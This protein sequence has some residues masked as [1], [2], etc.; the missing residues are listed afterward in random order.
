MSIFKISIEC[1]RTLIVQ[2]LL[3]TEETYYNTLLELNERFALPLKELGILLPDEHSCLFGAL[4]PLIGLSKDLRDRLRER[5]GVWDEDETKLGDVFLKLAPLLKLISSFAVGYTSA[6]QLYTKLRS[7]NE[8]FLSFLCANEEKSG[9][10]LMGLLICPIQRVPRYALLLKECV[11]HT[12]EDHP[13]YN[14]LQSALAEV[15]KIASDINENIR[16]VENELQLINIGKSFP[17]DDVNLLNSN[18][19]FASKRR[20]KSSSKLSTLK[21][22]KEK[23]E[24]KRLRK[25]AS[26][27]VVPE[28]FCASDNVGVGSENLSDTRKYL[29]EFSASVVSGADSKEVGESRYL[30][31]FNDL[32]L[33]A[34]I[35]SRAKK[36]YKL[37]ERVRLCQAWIGEMQ[38]N[39]ATCLTVGTPG[40]VYKAMLESETDGMK[41]SVVKDIQEAISKQKSFLEKAFLNLT[42]P[43]GKFCTKLFTLKSDYQT[44]MEMELQFRS[45]SEIEIVGVVDNTGKWHPSIYGYTVDVLG[46]SWWFGFCSGQCGFVPANCFTDTD[47]DRTSEPKPLSMKRFLAIRRKF[48][49][50]TKRR[51][52]PL[53]SR[54]AK[55]HGDGVQKVINVSEIADAARVIRQFFRRRSTVLPEDGKWFLREVSADGTVNVLLS[56]E[57]IVANRMNAWGKCQDMMH[58]EVEEKIS[59]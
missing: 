1:K 14:N 4:S 47:T 27:S 56:A 2:E 38:A 35:L 33:V 16:R 3:T 36:Q 58:F 43:D 28:F 19:Q 59:C 13:D 6:N 40:W 52:P 8:K 57:V 22:S 9:I 42:I 41:Q 18:R 49:E 39:D 54:L 12:D 48:S 46:C 17:Q 31:L 29:G 45:G 10:G 53:S 7:T 23:P 44:T 34:Q 5:I 25:Y 37:K 26:A 55:I 20:V 30:F 11:T 51:I 15:Q 50:W 21:E 32:V 24:N